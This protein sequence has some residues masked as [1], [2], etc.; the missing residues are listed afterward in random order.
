MILATITFKG[1]D[2]LAEHTV[3]CRTHISD[4]VS[5][6]GRCISGKRQ[7][8]VT[9]LLDSILEDAALSRLPIVN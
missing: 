2:R 4:D 8:D 5:H 7:R 3:E 6:T 1:E 9:W